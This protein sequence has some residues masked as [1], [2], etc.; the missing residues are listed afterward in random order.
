M[1][2]RICSRMT[3]CILTRTESADR[4]SASADSDGE[5]SLRNI[6]D[7]VG[8]RFDAV[9]RAA[10]LLREHGLLEESR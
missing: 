3:E 1:L 5:H 4:N 7:L 2:P 6:S 9:R 8:R 10:D